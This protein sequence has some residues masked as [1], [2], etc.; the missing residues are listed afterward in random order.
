MSTSSAQI[1]HI[2]I[3][4]NFYS[5][6]L[7]S[8]LFKDRTRKFVEKLGQNNS[9]LHED[10]CQHILSMQ[11]VLQYRKCKAGH[12]FIPNLRDNCRRP[13]ILYCKM[14]SYQRFSIIHRFPFYFRR[15]TLF[16]FRVREKVFKTRQIEKSFKVITSIK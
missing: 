5:H 11:T 3:L 12:L 8:F 15:K 2:K 9:R 4:C 7:Y 6:V 10:F 1:V 13:K 14:K 16:V